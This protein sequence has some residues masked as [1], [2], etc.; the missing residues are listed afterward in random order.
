MLGIPLSDASSSLSRISFDSRNVT[1]TF[2]PPISV[3]SDLDVWRARIELPRITPD[4]EDIGAVIR[5]AARTTSS[6]LV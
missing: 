4:A 6:R 2:V 3:W 1:E 5:S